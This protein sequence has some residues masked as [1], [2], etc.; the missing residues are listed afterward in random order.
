MPEL[1]FTAGKGISFTYGNNPWNEHILYAEKPKYQQALKSVNME[2][3]DTIDQL[4]ELGINEIEMSDL[5]NSESSY[6]N[7]HNNGFIIAVNRCL[8]IATMSRA[9]HCLR[10]TD[11]VDEKGKCIDYCSKETVLSIKRFYN[12]AESKHQDISPETK[13]IQP[14]M[15][16]HANITMVVD[17]AHGAK[18]RS[19]IDKLIDDERIMKYLPADQ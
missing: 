4:R 17:T 12:M 7:L 3:P 9:C 19:F 10:F 6:E 18:N 14:D 5:E 15:M 8:R 2:N 11:H 1:N 13:A 16:V